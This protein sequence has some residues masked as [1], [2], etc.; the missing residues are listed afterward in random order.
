M[1]G[2]MIGARLTRAAWPGLA[3]MVCAACSSLTQDI[4]VATLPMNSF[5]AASHHSYAWA[6]G[7]A[8]V[9]DPARVWS[10]PSFDVDAELKGSIGRELGRRGLSPASAQPDLLVR[11]RIGVAI[12]QVPSWTSGGGAQ[13]PLDVSAAELVVEI[14]DGRTSAPLWLGRATAKAAASGRPAD[15]VRARLDHA[16]AAMFEQ[17]PR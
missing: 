13:A 1:M 16:V 7:I 11:Y 4:E 5:S 14:Y 3:L 17:M 9:S 8:T 6:P 2:R 10:A 12:R 15:E